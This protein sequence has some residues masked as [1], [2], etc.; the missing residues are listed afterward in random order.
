MWRQTGIGAATQRP[1]VTE[2]GAASHGAAGRGK[3]RLQRGSR[4][5]GGGNP[6]HRRGRRTLPAGECAY[7]FVGA[8]RYVEEGVMR[9]GQR[10]RRVCGATMCVNKEVEEEHRYSNV[11]YGGGGGGG[12]QKTKGVWPSTCGDGVGSRGD[13]TPFG[14][15]SA[16]LALRSGMQDDVVVDED[17][18]RPLVFEVVQLRAAVSTSTPPACSPSKS[19]T[20][21]MTPP[22]A[23]IAR[24]GEPAVDARP[25]AA[26]YLVALLAPFHRRPRAW[27]GTDETGAA[28]GP[29]R[30]RA[31]SRGCA[32]RDGTGVAARMRAGRAKPAQVL[33][34]E[35]EGPAAEEQCRNWEEHGG[36]AGGRS[37]AQPLDPRG[38]F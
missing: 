10:A 30:T 37:R 18:L 19:Q 33:G 36:G 11:G 22:P 29:G 15:I 1:I 6:D 17:V 24:D 28:W 25:A 23:S 5:C 13:S 35:A 26:A 9:E 4:A 16:E 32:W 21:I 14:S 31:K 27:G 38:R 12:A 34:H 20:G 2:C 8:Q 7:P 3:Y